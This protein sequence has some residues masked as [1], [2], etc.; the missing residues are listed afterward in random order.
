MLY[1]IL[2]PVLS[3]TFVDIKENNTVDDVVKILKVLMKE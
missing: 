1:F 2:E 3:K